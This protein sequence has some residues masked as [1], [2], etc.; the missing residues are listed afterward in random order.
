MSGRKV[1]AIGAV[2]VAAMTAG[3]LGA[4]AAERGKAITPVIATPLGITTQPLGLAQGWGLGKDVAAELPRDRV[5]YTDLKGMTL[6]TYDKD[7]A[8]K[9]VCVDECAKTWPPMPAAANAKPY[10]DWS[11]ITRADGTKQWALKGKPLYRYFEDTTQG[12]VVGFN[13]EYIRNRGPLAGHR[14]AYYGPR[15]Q[16]KPMPEGWRVAM[17]YPVE[18]MKMPAGFK[19]NEVQDAGGITLSDEAGYTLYV[20]AADVARE[21]KACN[22]GPCSKQWI[23]YAAPSV[24]LPIGDFTTV[25]RADGISQWAYKGHPVYKFAGD[26]SPNLSNGDGVDPMWQVAYV[27]KYYMPDEIKIGSTASQGKILTTASG[28]TLYRRDGWLYQS[29][30]G[31]SFPR[32]QAARPAVGRDLGTE[33]HCGDQF[34]SMAKFGDCNVIWQPLLAA[35]DAQP[36]GFFDIYTRADGKKQWAYSGYALW[37]FAGDKKPGDINGHDT[38]DIVLSEDPNVLVNVP[39]PMDGSQALYWSIAVP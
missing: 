25:A 18:D 9:S 37:T 38:Y 12:S 2:A 20:M 24:G 39:T 22:G 10:G 16:A 1:L 35:D 26:Y 8:G 6:Y 3:Y 17:L 33:R 30:G 27:A 7:P 21:P 36:S 14:G 19:V 15:L 11:V 13:F 31:H 32:G 5:A 29:G 4:N 23:P 34:D 28:M